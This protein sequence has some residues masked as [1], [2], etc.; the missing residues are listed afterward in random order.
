MNVSAVDRGLVTIC[1]ALSLLPLDVSRGIVEAL[2]GAPTADPTEMRGGPARLPRVVASRRAAGWR[3]AARQSPDPDASGSF[4]EAF[5]QIQKT[6]QKAFYDRGLLGAHWN[7]IVQRYRARL[8]EAQTRPAFQN[9]INAMLG[10][11]KASHTS[12]VVEDDIEFFLFHA[13]RES[14]LKEY[15][16]EHIGMLGQRTDRG[17]LVTAVLEGYPA[18]RAGIR[19][20]DTLFDE[21]GAPV[22]SAGS[23]RG[24]SGKKVSL[25]V[26]RGET[27]QTLV[28]TPV[29]ENV[30][31]SFLEASRRSAR[32][33][34]V[35]GRRIAYLHLWTMAHR[36][37]QQLLEARVVGPLYP[38]DGLV[39][40]LRDGFGGHLDGF[41]DVFFRPDFSWEMQ[42]PSARPSV[43]HTGYG[44]PMV[45]LINRGTRSAKELL[46]YTL[47]Q[48][49]RARVVGTNTAGAVL[50]AGFF[51]IGK[52]ALLELAVTDMQFDR[53]RLEGVGVAPDVLVEPSGPYTSHDRQLQQAQQE[54]LRLLQPGQPRYAP[55][56][57]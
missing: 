35:G 56:I 55:A 14:T 45:V 25:R 44:K 1:L 41:A 49:H 28:V 32:I 26:L 4:T 46:S 10:E 3:T 37:F 53:M 47:K 18:E 42:T 27:V 36:A 52:Q 30:L 57:P 12:Y 54:L 7:S 40:D 11:L 39:L 5:E 9:V 13:V 43:L 20:G 31:Q 29:R 8:P 50:G 19:V 24:K 48:S 34:P 15:R 17:F 22:T 38:A 16:A 33:V 23:F 2:P 6:V 51:P 21:K